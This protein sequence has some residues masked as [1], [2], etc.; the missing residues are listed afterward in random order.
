ML[1]LT[2]TR[3]IGERLLRRCSVNSEGGEADSHV[4]TCKEL[5][6]KRSSR[7]KG[8]G[9]GRCLACLRGLCGW[10]RVRGKEKGERL[11]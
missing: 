2:T 1:A 9:V 4:G 3:E 5:S 6:R 11:G 8:P 7:Y 10:R